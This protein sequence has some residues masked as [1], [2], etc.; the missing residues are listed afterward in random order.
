LHWCFPGASVISFRASVL[1]G[2]LLK[3]YSW[4]DSSAGPVRATVLHDCIPEA[5]VPCVVPLLHSGPSP[6][7]LRSI[8]SAVH[9]FP[10]SD[11]PQIPSNGN[12]YRCITFKSFFC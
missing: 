6:C 7:R 9:N 1:Y 12:K 4:F 11:F 8:P 10:G 2:F 3:I 5:R